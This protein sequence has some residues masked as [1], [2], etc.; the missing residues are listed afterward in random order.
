MKIIW[1]WQNIFTITHA[2]LDFCD[3]TVI[4]EKTIICFI[5][6]NLDLFVFSQYYTMLQKCLL[7]YK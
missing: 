4:D 2:L 7:N 1:F 3:V 5:S 6:H